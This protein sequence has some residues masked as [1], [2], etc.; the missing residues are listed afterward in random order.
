MV[1]RKNTGLAFATFSLGVGAF[2]LLFYLALRKPSREFPGQK[3]AFLK[4]LDSRL[5]GWR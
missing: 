4:L 5:T 3:N 1:E 2:A